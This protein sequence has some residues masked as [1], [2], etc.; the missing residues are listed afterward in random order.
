VGTISL[1]GMQPLALGVYEAGNK[2]FVADDNSGDVKVVDGTT[3]NIVASTHVGSSAFDVI[4]NETYGKVYVASQINCCTTGLTSGNGLISVL[5]A[6]T[7]ALITQLNPGNSNGDSYF[8]LL[9][10]EVHDKV[11][12][13]FKSGMG[14]ID[15]ATDTITPITYN[16]TFFGVGMFDMA[17]NTVTNEVYY[18][19]YGQNMLLVVNGNTLAVQE[20]SLAPSGGHGPLDLAVNEAENKV[21]AT[22]ISVPGQGEIGILILDRDTGVFKFVGAEDLE[23]LEFNQDTNTL[24]SGVQVGQRGAIVDGATDQFTYIDLGGEG[25]GAGDVRTSTN[26]AYFVEQEGTHVV[27]GATKLVHTIPTGDEPRGG[28]FAYSV[29]IDQTR[30]LVY[31]VNDDEDGIV[32]VIQDGVIPPPP[33][34]SITGGP[35]AV[36]NDDT[37]TFEFGATDP[38]STFEC[39]L[40]LD[41]PFPFDPCS[42]PYTTARLY[43]GHHVLEVRAVAGGRADETPATRSFTVDTYAPQTAIYGGPSG[44]TKD[45][46]PTF[47]FGAD[48]SKDTFECKLDAKAWAACTSPKT[49]GKLAFGRHTFRVRATDPAGNVDPTPAVQNFKVVRP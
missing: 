44:K 18:I 35:P 28:L 20:L 41:E 7:G 4:V 39:R 47:R 31:V 24:F 49:Y 3:R 11:Y 22:M 14:V 42:S 17:V 21:Y 48:T 5:N 27:N 46:T 25:M 23:P 1:P 32:T 12:Y 29:A 15:V 13:S 36:T 6:N 40:D 43:D 30:G 37:P 26:N 45:R 10:D 8:R 9:G 34:T 38:D 16:G 33:D 19:Q 2:L